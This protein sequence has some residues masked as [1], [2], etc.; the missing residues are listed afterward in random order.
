MCSRY[1]EA[2]VERL[3]ADAAAMRKLPSHLPDFATVISL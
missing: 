3:C 1:I 2:R